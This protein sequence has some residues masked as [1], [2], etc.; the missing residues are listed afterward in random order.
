MAVG[1]MKKLG[2]M[3]LLSIFVLNIS[4]AF[5]EI[6]MTETKSLQPS[7]SRQLVKS[8]IIDLTNDKNLTEAEFVQQLARYDYV[9]LGE[10]HDSYAQHQLALWLLEA[11][12]KQRPQA[13]LLLEML[14]VDQQP[15][16]DEVLQRDVMDL[17]EL[18]QSLKWQSSWDWGLYGKIVEHPVKHHYELV[19]TNLSTAEVSSLMQK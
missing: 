11:L 7:L 12:H 8:Q 9:I 18:K 17:S 3:M 19:A 6:S 4:T 14:R 5:A 15:M 2:K 16:V 1:N 13:S 10:Y